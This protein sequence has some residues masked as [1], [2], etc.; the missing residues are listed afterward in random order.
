MGHHVSNRKA[1]NKGPSTIPI[2]TEPVNSESVAR[3]ATPRR[4]PRHR[5]VSPL[6]QPSPRLDAY[7][8]ETAPLKSPPLRSSRPRQSVASAT[9]SASRARTA[10]VTAEKANTSRS[11]PPKKLPEMV[12]VDFA[13]RRK[14]IQQAF[15]KSM[16][17]NEQEEE[18]K[19]MSLLPDAQLLKSLEGALSER[20]VSKTPETVVE[21]GLD[22][23]KAQNQEGEVFPTPAEEASQN[24]RGLTID[25]AKAQS[26]LKKTMVTM[27]QEDSPTLGNVKFEES[28][29]DQLDDSDDGPDSAVTTG[30]AET[31]FDN[32]PQE[33]STQV[34]HPAPT[35]HNVQQ[36]LETS[37]A[38]LLE[39]PDDL[40]KPSTL[41]GS[42]QDDGESIQIMLG[43]T[44]I[45]ERE[46]RFETIGRPYDRGETDLNEAWDS[47]K[48]QVQRESPVD[49]ASPAAVPSTNHASSSSASTYY[50]QPWSPESA[51]SAISGQTLD[52]E[53]YNTIN[54]VLDAYHDPSLMSPENI[55]EI[56]RRLF[57]QSPGLARAGGWDTK[58]VTQLYLQNLRSSRTP[59]PSAIPKPLNVHSSTDGSPPRIEA[60]ATK[61][62]PSPGKAER[63]T[64]SSDLGGERVESTAQD[65]APESLSVPAGSVNLQRAS[66]NNPDDWLNTSPSMLDWI[67]RQAYDS[68]TDANDE[69]QSEKLGEWDAGATHPSTSTVKGERPVLPD[70]PRGG[71]GII[72]I[73]VDSSPDAR[74]QA[75]HAHPN[76]VNYRSSPLRSMQ[77]TS[78][79]SPIRKPVP[80]QSSLNNLFQTPAKPAS[81]RRSIESSIIMQADEPLG[82]GP[83]VT[84]PKADDE[85]IVTDR[86]SVDGPSAST[87]SVAKSATVAPDVQ[88][89]LTRRRHVLKEMIDTE[90]SFGQDMTVV[91]DIYRGTSNVILN[92]P[93]DVKTLFG[94]AHEIVAFSTAFL[95]SLKNSVKSVYTL[96]KSKRWRSKRDSNATTESTNTDEQPSANGPDLNDEEKDRLT[97]IGNAFLEHIGDMER[98]YTD[99][100]KNHDSANQ[101]LQQLQKSQKVQIWLKEC[102]TYANDLT[103]A[104]D[105]DSLLVKPVQRLLKYGLFLKELTEV[106]PEN[107]PDFVNIDTAAREIKGVSMRINDI[108]KRADY[109]EQVIGGRKNRKDSEGRI[110]LTKRFNLRPEKFKPQLGMADLFQDREYNAISDKFGSHFF[111]LQ[112]V[113]RDVEMYAEEAQS[114]VS[115]FNDVVLAIEAYMDVNQTTYPEVESKWRRFRQSMR[116]IQTTALTDHVSSVTD[117]TV[118]SLTIIG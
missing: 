92:S 62:E 19:R 115:K 38:P 58:K 83:D 116:E 108:K 11:N 59:D 9:T 55:S 32:E 10:A 75:S 61:F 26:R 64:A 15:T 2:P 42:D 66:L 113:M 17:E 99:Y 101:K 37:N 24:D 5:N 52:S 16:I 46:Q 3:V 69:K 57:S 60:P 48:R 118:N 81:P 47:G 84:T 94:N 50:A 27:N 8:S 95:D 25:T 110:A 89:R 36:D 63:S 90:S 73:N 6:R 98:V 76:A 53:S 29:K 86:M 51:S 23:Q 79:A 22:E 88:K 117:V 87:E 102:Q 112:V 72:D 114:W 49:A 56:Q 65:R 12:T 77:K 45:T 1:H 7:I 44:P 67:H 107:H 106:T 85:S 103:T 93:E 74:V 31:F 96:P 54:R 33:T 40:R 105:L 18:K 91:V 28:G 4:S 30:T 100:L 39:S 20:D 21:H 82:K 70:I 35:E 34:E 111:Q 14:R 71:L 109:M 41:S 104:W 80:G 97:S 68:P 78:P 13:A 43:E